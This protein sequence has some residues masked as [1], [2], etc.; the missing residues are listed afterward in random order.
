[1]QR[2]HSLKLGWPLQGR[3]TARRCSSSSSSE[4]DSVFLRSLLAAFLR[5][6]SLDSDS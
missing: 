5:D 3:T 4:D 1:M 6:R 2:Q